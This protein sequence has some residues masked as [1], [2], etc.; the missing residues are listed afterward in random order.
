MGLVGRLGAVVDAEFGQDVGDVGADGAAAD[1]EG[2][3][4]LGIGVAGR[5]QPEDFAFALGQTAGCRLARPSVG[6]RG[7]LRQERVG[8]GEGVVQRQRAAGGRGRRP[9]GLADFL[10]AM[11]GGRIARP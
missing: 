1:E 6:C 11:G 7:D 8:L 4:D 9:F 10:Y 5:N 2:L 3:R